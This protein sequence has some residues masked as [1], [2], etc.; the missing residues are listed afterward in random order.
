VAVA[1]AVQ[2]QRIARRPCVQAEV[3]V[4]TFGNAEIGNREGEMVQGMDTEHALAPCLCLRRLVGH[5][6]P[7]MIREQD[8]C[9]P[10]AIASRSSIAPRQHGRF[11][12]QRGAFAL[13]FC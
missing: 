12:W 10:L 13:E 9:H 7:A 11:A 1:E 4:E 5:G 6:F 3:I 8:C 2:V